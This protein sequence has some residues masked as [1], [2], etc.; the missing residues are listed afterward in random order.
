VTDDQG[1][2][3]G[4]IFTRICALLTKELR[5]LLRDRQALLLLFVMP[6]VFILFLSLAMQNVFE[7]KV[8]LKLPVLIHN[9]DEGDLG[10]KI[11]QNLLEIP[12]LS[13]MQI[14]KESNEEQEFLSGNLKAIIEIPAGFTDTFREFSKSETQQLSESSR[15]RWTV[16]PLLDAT[17]RWFVKGSL[18]VS[19]Q[20]ALLADLTN[21]QVEGVE[22]EVADTK[23]LKSKFQDGLFAE[24]H[25]PGSKN[26]I[27]PNPLQQTVP[28]WSLFAMFFIVI[29]LSNSFYREVADG[30][31][32]RIGTY[33]V[34]PWEIVF[35]KLFPFLFINFI[36]FVLML[37]VGLFVIPLFSDIKLHMASSPFLLV[38]VTFFCA[39]AA[40]AFGVL[41]SSLA[42][43][44]EQAA[45]IGASSV[46]TMAVL[47]GIMV[48]HFVMP[49]F[50]QKLAYI[51]PLYW[52]MQSY[53][54]VI[55]KT[56]G[57]MTIV[58]N[59]L[60]LL[61]FSVVCFVIAS[62]RLKVI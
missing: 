44:A 48:P 49:P 5:I 4:A 60:V 12:E 45:A 24:Y 57:F 59:L 8:G 36:Q 30:T 34:A 61:L 7:Q 27:I 25:F 39:L 38:P 29:P 40:T 16:D 33:P 28:A 22:Q 14:P 3:C 19:L 20:Q 2:H 51:S 50:M 9:R 18:I 26:F 13:P 31:L 17:Y 35:G 58:P 54:D 55:L 21:A 52:G 42:R 32:R 41:I 53:L 15:I 56:S 11:L 10:A 6:M 43:T 1:S 23:R 47:G 46:V 37:C 62:R